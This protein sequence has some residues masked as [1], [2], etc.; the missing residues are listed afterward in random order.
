VCGD[1]N[2]G[3]I[4]KKHGPK[5]PCPVLRIHILTAPYLSHFT[6]KSFLD[7]AFMGVEVR[8]APSASDAPW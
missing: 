6:A 2:A 3:R 8:E 4:R 7:K 1:V 5:I